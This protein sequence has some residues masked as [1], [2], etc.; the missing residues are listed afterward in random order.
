MI[1]RLITQPYN[2][3]RKN[4]CKKR[5]KKK[6]QQRSGNLFVF[7]W[8]VRSRKKIN[9][10]NIF[11]RDVI[12]KVDVEQRQPKK[13]KTF[14]KE[15]SGCRKMCRRSAK[16]R[17]MLIFLSLQNAICIVQARFAGKIQFKLFAHTWMKKHKGHSVFVPRWVSNKLLIHY[18]LCRKFYS[19]SLFYFHFSRVSFLCFSFECIAPHHTTPHRV[20][21]GTSKSF[22]E[23]QEIVHF[24]IKI[25]YGGK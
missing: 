2:T 19:A 21:H 13:E 11:H 15:E 5:T 16:E 8:K 25:N 18:M 7:K 10:C 14:T 20:P 22:A 4:I 9:R 12:C 23:F 17:K 3:M 24:V 6:N 1:A